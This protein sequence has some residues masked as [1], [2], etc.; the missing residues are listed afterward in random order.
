MMRPM[1]RI[2]TKHQLDGLAFF[3]ALVCAV[4]SPHWA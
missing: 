1:N 4:L 3:A 2:L